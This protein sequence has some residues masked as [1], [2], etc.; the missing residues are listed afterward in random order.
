[1]QRH[2]RARAYGIASIQKAL[3]IEEK[4]WQNNRGSIGLQNGGGKAFQ[5]IIGIYRRP[6]VHV[7]NLEVGSHDIANGE[8]SKLIHG[9]LVDVGGVG[10]NEV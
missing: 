8:I 4:H 2:G 5:R 6:E 7:Q 9:E 10:R 3:S 1:M